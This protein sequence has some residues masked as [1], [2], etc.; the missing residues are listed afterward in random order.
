MSTAFVYCRV[1]TREQTEGVS[2]EVQE[3]DG[4]AWCDANAYNK[5]VF[6]DAGWSGRRYDRPA[7]TDMLSRLSE[8]E[9][10][11][12]WKMDRLARDNVDRGL[13]LRELRKRD[14]AL[15]SVTQPEVSGDS[16]ESRLVSG[17]LGAVAEFESALIGARV[18]AGQRRR[19]EQGQQWQKPPYGYDKE[20]Q[21]VPE[22]V[23]V[24]EEID[25]LYLSGWG[26]V[27]VA[28]WL[29]EQSYPTPT[30]KGPWW[31]RGVRDILVR[32]T[33]SGVLQW[34]KTRRRGPTVRLKPREEWIEVQT[35]VAIIRPPERW[36]RILTRMENR[37]VARASYSDTLFSGL[38]WCSC[39]G[40]MSTYAWRLRTT[41]ETRRAY[42]CSRRYG[43]GQCSAGAPRILEGDLLTA[44]TDAAAELVNKAPL[45]V[46]NTP[47]R[48]VIE[49]RLRNL[50]ARRQRTREAYL[51]GQLE[52]DE[53]DEETELF[54]ARRDRLEAR[55]KRAD[56]AS[57]PIPPATVAR[58]LA[59]PENRDAAAGWLRDVVDRIE[60]DGETLDVGWQ[61]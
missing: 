44:I 26:T 59:G 19:A 4:V 21:P 17:V 60:W 14:V 8:A 35:D 47:D 29:N 54:R 45:I 5:V 55:L 6:V 49:Q 31:G 37:T 12:V 50:Q 13:I 23:E 15:V 38:L 56:P 16:P 20:W 42:R 33:Y 7:L 30:G 57:E 34:G 40:R 28:V 24:I 32:S 18:R 11:V 51:S 41:G 25:R 58:L 61:L 3:A 9:V 36:E 27:R 10:V 1:S 39:G 22:Q 46:P 53:F 2:L 52:L 43:T 48:D